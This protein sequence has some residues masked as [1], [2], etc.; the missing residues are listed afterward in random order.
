MSVGE[1][2]GFIC[3]PSTWVRCGGSNKSK[4][5]MLLLALTSLLLLIFSN[6]KYF[7]CTNCNHAD[8][9]SD[10][11]SLP[12]PYTPYPLHSATLIIQV[13]QSTVTWGAKKQGLFADR[14]LG[15]GCSHRRYRLAWKLPAC[16]LCP[17]LVSTIC[18]ANFRVALAPMTV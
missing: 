9:D 12:F 15:C 14:Q 10:T 4:R 17:W 16:W 18:L 1:E 3:R 7:K 8:T 13:P 2:T 11:T 6:T 5:E